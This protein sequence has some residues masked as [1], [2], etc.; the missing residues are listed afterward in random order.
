MSISWQ[1]N[2][3]K[4]SWAL[5]HISHVRHRR[6]MG[7]RTQSDCGSRNKLSAARRRMTHLAE[8]VRSRERCNTGPMFELKGRKDGPKTVLQKGTS[9][10]RTFWNRRGAQQAC[11]H[12]IR[13]R[14]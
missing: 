5:G 2:L 11:N 1:L 12:Y 3:T 6:H 14:A 8:M 13:S 10:G 4:Y 9:K 7:K